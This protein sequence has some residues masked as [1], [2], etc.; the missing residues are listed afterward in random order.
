MPTLTEQPHRINSPRL[1]D[2]E[3][4]SSS[5][6]AVLASIVDAAQLHAA[7][8]QHTPDSRSRPCGYELRWAA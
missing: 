7:Q 4:I 6:P 5:L 1:D 3:H 8:N 2:F